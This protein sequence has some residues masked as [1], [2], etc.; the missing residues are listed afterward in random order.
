MVWGEGEDQQFAAFKLK[1]GTAPNTVEIDWIMAGPE[2]RKGV[3]SRA[4]KEL[5]RQAQESGIRLTLYPWAK[6]NVSQAS[7]TR[8]YKRHG[9]KPI[10]KGAKPMAWE[11]V[12]EI[13]DD[14]RCATGIMEDI[15]SIPALIN[16][17]ADVDGI[18][19]SIN[20]NATNASLYATS[21]GKRLGYAEFDRDGNTLLPYDL[22]VDDKY[23]GQGIAAVM[24]D[25]AKSLGFTINASTEQTDAGKYFWKKNRGEERVWEDSINEDATV[26]KEIEFVC[27]NPG[28]KGATNKQA[29]AK[30][31][32]FL[33]Q[34]PGA[35]PL[36][37]DWDHVESGQKSLTAIYKD[38]T[39]RSTI[40]D[41]AKKLGIAVDLEQEVD[42]NYVDRA[43]RGEHEGQINEVTMVNTQSRSKQQHLDVMPNDGR[44]IPPGQESDYLG[45]L[46]AEMGNGLQLWSWTDRGTV[47]YYVFD[48][49]SRTS[50]LGT[51]GRPYTSNRNSFVVQ[52]VYSGPKNQYRAADLY[53]FLILNRGLTLVSDNKQSEGGYRVWQELER[54]Y[55]NK[56]NIHGF[57][58]KT[59]QG[60]NVTTRD[61]PETHVDR[62]TVKRAGPQMKKELG[63]ISR[64]L[65]FVASKK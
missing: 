20:T 5:Q 58:T 21:N 32:Q 17:T 49:R 35:I 23:R 62:E 11:P 40:L 46:V 1:P 42:G 55:G 15:E 47:T 14:L 8:L 12:N 18:L 16:K 26:Y 34:V 22:E 65:R 4:I 24:Y 39:V 56:I 19:V 44:P 48:T 64:D 29:Q 54:R 27:V 33:K 38:P 30:L 13:N 9:F 41:A 45:D 50:Q 37:Q 53:A 59:D 43:I 28:S 10:A 51:T 63:T 25:Y 7:L 3:G 61:E 36:W 6:G 57:D 31:Y 2:Q 52:G 60:V